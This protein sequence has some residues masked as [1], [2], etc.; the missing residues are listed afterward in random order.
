MLPKVEKLTLRDQTVVY[1]GGLRGAVTLA[2]A[3]S[4]PVELPYGWMVQSIAFGV[5]LFSVF[6]Q[7][8]TIPFLLKSLRINHKNI[9]KIRRLERHAMQALRIIQT[10]NRSMPFIFM[11]ANVYDRKL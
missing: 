11:R 6:I 2:L 9:Q 1:W 10:N 8:P 5:V 3:L 4:I 7:A